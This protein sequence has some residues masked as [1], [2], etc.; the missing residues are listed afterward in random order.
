MFF[1]Y[2]L[3]YF[4]ALLACLVKKY[5]EG[6]YYQMSQT[7]LLKVDMSSAV[8]RQEDTGSTQSKVT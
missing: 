3:I 2:F 1:S 4:T 5:I 7:N 8:N 6:M